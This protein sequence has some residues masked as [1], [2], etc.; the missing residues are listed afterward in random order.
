MVVAIKDVILWSRVTFSK[1]TYRS[2]GKLFY[3]FHQIPKSRNRSKDFII[4]A[5]VAS[6]NHFAYEHEAHFYDKTA[7]IIKLKKESD[8]YYQGIQ[9]VM[10]SSSACFFMK[11]TCQQKQLT[12]GDG[13]RVEFISKV[14]YQFS[15]TA[16]GTTP[17]PEAGI[18][19]TRVE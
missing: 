13:V 5:E 2:A 12:G 14:P 9:A 15:G 1:E 8:K 4:F 3:E 19:R 16:V 11:Q 6:H 18:G 10:N 7:P 17:L